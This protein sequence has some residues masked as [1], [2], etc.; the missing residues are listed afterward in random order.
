[1]KKEI[2]I[3]E[4][5]NNH[6]KLF[7]DLANVNEMIKGEDKALIFLSSLPN[8]EYETIVL[9]LINDKSSLSYDEVSAAPVNHELR[10]KDKKS[11]SSTSIE[12]LIARGRSSNWKGKGDLEKSKSKFNNR[13]LRKD[14][15]AFCKENGY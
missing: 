13:N 7:I 15:C 10:R 8:D 6:T 2:S 14:Q 5:I 4:Y 1:M 3:G 12:V 11:S 9:T